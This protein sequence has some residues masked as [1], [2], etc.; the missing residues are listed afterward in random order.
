MARSLNSDSMSIARTAQERHE[1]LQNRVLVENPM[2]NACRDELT[3]LIR[4]EIT[5]KHTACLTSAM[6]AIVGRLMFWNAAAFPQ[7]VDTREFSHLVR[8][9]MKIS[10]S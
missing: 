4:H 2:E 1:I 8:P 7:H 5:S 9:S 3:V 6:K 10:A